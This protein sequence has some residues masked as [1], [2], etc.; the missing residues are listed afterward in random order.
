MESNLTI[1]IQNTSTV[2]QSNIIAVKFIRLNKS[3]QVPRKGSPEAAGW[4]LFSCDA[5]TLPPA[6]PTPSK[7]N[8]G[9]ALEFPPNSGVYARIASRSGLASRGIVIEGG[10][11]D[12]DYTGPICVLLRN[13]GNETYHMAAGTRIAQLVFE[14]FANNI[15]LEETFTHNRE[16]IRGHCGFGSTGDQ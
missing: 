6:S 12:P 13:Y 3:A 10:V 2:E 4:D 8:T 5:T 9:I 7:V 11:V 15:V 16:T 14:K 1:T